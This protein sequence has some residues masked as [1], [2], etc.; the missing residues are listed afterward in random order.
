M[1]AAI[2]AIVQI[3]DSSFKEQLIEM[4]KTDPNMNIRKAAMK[5]VDEI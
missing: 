5:A 1:I 2:N 3:Q 4:S